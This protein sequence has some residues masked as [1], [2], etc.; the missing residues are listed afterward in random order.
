MVGRADAVPVGRDVTI[1]FE[2]VG[3]GDGEPALAVG[4]GDPVG[5]ALPVGQ[6]D[7]VGYQVGK[8]DPVGSAL[9]V[10]QGEPVGYAL[11]VGQGDTVGY[12]G[13]GDGE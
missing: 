12:E 13:E 1:V 3:V 9:P 6:G 2:G 10:G 5:Y 7:I 11:P 8:A 4:Q